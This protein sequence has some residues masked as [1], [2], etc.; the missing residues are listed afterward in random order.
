M[1]ALNQMLLSM[2]GNPSF[3]MDFIAVSTSTISNISYPA[4]AQAGDL[5]ILIDLETAGSAPSLVTPSGYD[6]LYNNAGSAS[7]L[8]ISIKTLT[9]GDTGAV[10]GMSG[11]K[12]LGGKSLWIY[13]P[14][15]PLSNVTASSPGFQESVSAP[16]NQLVSSGAL[17]APVLVFGVCASNGDVSTYAMS[18]A[19]TR[20]T[21]AEGLKIRFMV[22]EY[23]DP[24]ADVTVSMGDFSS[25]NIMG[26]V[27][28][29]FTA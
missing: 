20:E 26:S 13:R 17:A 7:R 21:A 3:T 28:L 24:P 19:Q 1:S 9:S 6:T 2:A 23:N 10:V 15:T 14:S 4:G 29:K 22:K 8:A 18:P 25:Q 5:A 16:T 11:G 12:S 27:A